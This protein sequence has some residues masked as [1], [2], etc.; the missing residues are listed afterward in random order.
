MT[1]LEIP[2]FL[3]VSVVLIHS[4][5]GRIQTKYPAFT[6]GIGSVVLQIHITDSGNLNV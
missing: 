4:T 5:S 1:A 2:G 6:P 3:F